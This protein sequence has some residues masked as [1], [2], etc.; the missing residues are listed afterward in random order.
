MRLIP[1]RFPQERRRNPK[2]WAEARV[3][4]ALARSGHQG[5]AI[6]EWGAAE[7]PHQLD[8]ALWLTGIGRFA[9]EVKGGRYTLKPEQDRWH[10]H[11]PYGVEARPSPLDQVTVAAQDLRRAIRRCAHRDV[12][13]IPTVVFADMAP[14]PAIERRAESAGV[15]VVWGAGR[16]LADLE[17]IAWRVDVPPAPSADQVRNEV[18][19][20]NM[21]AAHHPLAGTQ[22]A[23]QA[24]QG[25]KFSAVPDVAIR[26]V[27]TVI[28]RRLP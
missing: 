18:Q 9:I 21:G 7:R 3:F 22:D 5:C 11:T 26:H 4:D 8:F 24:E 1:E 23:G 13:V 16:L 14:D 17:A 2:R 20:V 28:V 25:R 15:Q 12:A 27:G 6:Y 10:L 19:A